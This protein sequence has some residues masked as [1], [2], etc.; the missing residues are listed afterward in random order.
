MVIETAIKTALE[1][2]DEWDRRPLQ[3]RVAILVKAADLACGKYR[4]ELAASCMLGQV[5]QSLQR[6]GILQT[7]LLVTAMDN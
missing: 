2:R 1:A 4:A 6:Q 3:E 7:S 5:I